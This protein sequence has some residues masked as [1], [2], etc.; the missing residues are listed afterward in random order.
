VVLFAIG[1]GA[2]KVMTSEHYLNKTN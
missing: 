1:G 2:D